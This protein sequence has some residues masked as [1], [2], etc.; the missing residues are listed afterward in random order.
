MSGRLC[1]ESE[2]AKTA[3]DQRKYEEKKGNR[4]HLQMVTGGSVEPGGIITFNGSIGTRKITSDVPWHEFCLKC[5]ATHLK[6]QRNNNYL[7][8][9]II[10]KHTIRTV[11]TINATACVKL[12]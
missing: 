7:K 5:A 10:I 12:W 2:A 11:Y 3:A 8:K 9:K 4:R 1:R 6:G